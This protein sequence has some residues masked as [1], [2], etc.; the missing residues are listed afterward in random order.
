MGWRHSL[1]GSV[2]E[3]HPAGSCPQRCSVTPYVG[4]WLKPNRYNEGGVASKVTPYV[5]SVD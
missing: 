5:R 4:V 2:V 1:C 3:T